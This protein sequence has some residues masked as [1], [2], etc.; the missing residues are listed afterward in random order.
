[1]TEVESLKVTV[2]A[3]VKKRVVGAVIVEVVLTLDIGIE[4]VGCHKISVLVVER[5]YKEIQKGA[6]NVICAGY[7]LKNTVR[8]DRRDQ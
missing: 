8:G 7:R 2:L 3:V 1:M 4:K 5:R 6:S